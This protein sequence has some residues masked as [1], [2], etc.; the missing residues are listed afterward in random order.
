[1]ADIRDGI[2]RA[3]AEAGAGDQVRQALAEPETGDLFATPAGPAGDEALPVAPSAA[4][5]GRG[6]PPGARNRRTTEVAAYLVARHGDPLEGLLAIG[7][8]SLADTARELWRAIQELEA[9]GV[10]FALKKDQALGIDLGE[11]MK[12]KAKCLEAALPYIHARRAPTD[13]KGESV[14]PVLN[15]NLP[16][17]QGGALGTAGG[18]S[19]DDFLEVDPASGEVLE[20]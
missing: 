15:L 6:R 11:V 9:E 8:G 16:A 5:R 7:M 4:K 10:K 12:L 1:M 17:G 3:V 13:E 14:V 18:V 20:K 19:I 2:S